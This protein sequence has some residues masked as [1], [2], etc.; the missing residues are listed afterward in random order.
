MTDMTSPRYTAKAIAQVLMDAPNAVQ[1]LHTNLRNIN[2]GPELRI[3]ATAGVTNW[4]QRWSALD[5]AKL[6]VLHELQRAGAV[7]GPA[8]RRAVYD[9]LSEWETEICAAAN[10]GGKF[11][12]LLDP[13]H[14]CV[15]AD[16]A[17]SL[18][19]PAADHAPLF[20]GVAGHFLNLTEAVAP[21]VDRL[22][23]L[24]MDTKEN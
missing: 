13:F 16:L 6:C 12:L 23:A 17:A 20:R 1:L 2:C 22:R 3:P 21:M 14:L 7:L 9:A 10:G 19:N 18:S 5:A 4:E 11:W 8:Q 15:T 24:A